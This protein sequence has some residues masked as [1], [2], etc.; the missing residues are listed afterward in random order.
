MVQQDA[1][2]PNGQRAAEWS[3]VGVM[4]FKGM[5]GDARVALERRCCFRR[6]APQQTILDYRDESSDVFF[7]VMRAPCR[8]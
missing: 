6:Y 1:P 5:P 8:G 2:C 7:V 3:L 4:L